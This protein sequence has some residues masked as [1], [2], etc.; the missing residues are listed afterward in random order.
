MLAVRWQIESG[1]PVRRELPPPQDLWLLSA[2]WLCGR[3]LHPLDS[4]FQLRVLAGFE[5]LGPQRNKDVGI[6]ALFI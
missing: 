2:R 3:S 6:H 5:L 1:P 4:L